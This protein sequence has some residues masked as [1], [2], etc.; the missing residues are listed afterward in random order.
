MQISNMLSAVR[1]LTAVDVSSCK[2]PFPSERC[3]SVYTVRKRN[4]GA[5][6][7]MANEV[8]SSKGQFRSQQE[9]KKNTLQSALLDFVW[10]ICVQLCVRSYEHEKQCPPPTWPSSHFEFSV[11]L[12]LFFMEFG[13]KNS[14][15][16]H[17]LHSSTT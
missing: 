9:K 4:R 8:T 16:K 7:N 17:K 14:F 6:T 12:L 13:S 15:W 3:D 5:K 10:S 2:P 1:P 11:Q